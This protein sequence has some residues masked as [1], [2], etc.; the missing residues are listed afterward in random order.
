MKSILNNSRWRSKIFTH[1]TTKY[2]WWCCWVKKGR[3]KK[4]NNS[5]WTIST[6]WS[7]QYYKT[8]FVSKYKIRPKNVDWPLL[9][10]WNICNILKISW[11]SESQN[12]IIALS[13]LGQNLFYIIGSCTSI[14]QGDLTQFIATFWNKRLQI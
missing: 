7:N 14:F 3:K 2:C 13:F 11:R 4:K 12:L 6:L 5:I 8:Y 9:Q 10:I 1:L